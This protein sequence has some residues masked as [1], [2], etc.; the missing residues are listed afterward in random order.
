MALLEVDGL[1]A[2]YGRI[3]VLRE[4]SFNAHEGGLSLFLGPNGAG[5]T[6]LLRAI[7]GL[8]D[9]HGGDA[10]VGG[11][12]LVGKRTF[13]IARMGVVHVPEGRQLFSRMSVYEN[14][15]LGCQGK[16]LR[17]RRDELVAYVYSLFPILKQRS[18]QKAGTL[19]GGEQQ[20]LAI[21]RALMSD[22]RVLMLDEPSTGLAPR[23]FG[24]VLEGLGQ[25]A[26]DGKS[27]IL[28][29][30]LVPKSL[31]AGGMGYILMDGRIVQS[32]P[33]DDV[34]HMEGLWENYLGLTDAA[35][36]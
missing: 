9:V 16:A 14:L 18:S 12:S 27:V 2:G 17:G 34:I 7:S 35:H 10:R 23:I 33:V 19:S 1:S 21:G 22:P 5:K 15:D 24:E 6:T 36:R 20:M 32:G 31:P 3:G 11:E 25:I 26:R 29:E 28:V 8:C 13:A 4:V 30:Q